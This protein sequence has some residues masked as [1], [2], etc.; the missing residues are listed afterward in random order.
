MILSQAGLHFSN[1][2]IKFGKFLSMLSEIQVIF[3]SGYFLL[4]I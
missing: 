3:L 2:L 4:Q 1:I